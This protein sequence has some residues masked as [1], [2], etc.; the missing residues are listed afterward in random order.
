MACLS[1][2]WIQKEK[3]WWVQGPRE[4]DINVRS[5]LFSQ[6]L[7]FEWFCFLGDELIYLNA[8]VAISHSEHSTC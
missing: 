2:Q 7:L 1:V 8:D 6:K 4:K 3:N 5:L